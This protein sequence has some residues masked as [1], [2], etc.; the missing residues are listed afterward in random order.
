MLGH[1]VDAAPLHGHPTELRGDVDDRAAALT[2]VGILQHA[3]HGGLRNDECGA[4][5]ELKQFV[6]SHALH[7][8]EWLRQICS[9][10]VDQDVERPHAR[11]GFLDSCFVEN[12]EDQ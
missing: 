10:V 1:G 9:G 8:N 12:V 5:I 3:P 4:D 2:P 6:E 11:E 7:F